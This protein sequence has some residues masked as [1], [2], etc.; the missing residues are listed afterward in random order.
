MAG[1]KILVVDDDDDILELLMYDLTRQGYLVICENSGQR[2]VSVVQE[3]RPDLI[4][5]DVMLPTFSGLEICRLL[6]SDAVAQAI[7][8]IMLSAKGE[9]NDVVAGLEC[10]ADDYVTKPF[11]TKVLGT[12][13]KTVLRKK[14]NGSAKSEQPLRVG[15]IIIDP[16][17]REVTAAGEPI[18]L[19]NIEFRLLHFLASK[20]GWAFTRAQIVDAVQGEEHA[21]TERSVDV[22]L[23]GLRKKL[24]KWSGHIETVR[25]LGYRF[26]E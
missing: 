11:S 18:A 12:R 4:V 3:S 26:R 22:Q 14:A 16:I 25:G 21:A 8:I 6:K 9:E 2:A 23:S 15:E 19:T 10:G 5:L 7:P 24:G 13:I 17:T 1:E 20:P